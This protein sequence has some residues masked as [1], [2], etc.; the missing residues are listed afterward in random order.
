M[1]SNP[2][3]RL[4]PLLSNTEVRLKPL[5]SNTEVRLKRLLSVIGSVKPM[6]ITGGFACLLISKTKRLIIY[7]LLECVVSV[8]DLK[9]YNIEN[10]SNIYPRPDGGLYVASKTDVLQVDIHVTNKG[11]RG[12]I[13]D[14]KIDEAIESDEY[15]IRRYPPRHEIVD[16]KIITVKCNEKHENEL[17]YQ[18]L[19]KKIGLL[20]KEE[21]FNIQIQAGV[22]NNYGYHLFAS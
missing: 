17:K 21:E 15:R 4:K 16:N 7:A 9:E 13:I 8:F 1:L 5:L 14:T 12:I 6:C 20:G 22:Q 2:E 3:V 10:K 19:P 18:M 11:I